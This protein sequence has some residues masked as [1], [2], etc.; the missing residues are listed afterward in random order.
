MF[1]PPMRLVIAYG[2]I[3][4]MALA[5]VGIVVW[6]RHNNPRRRYLR[7]KARDAEYYRRRDQAA[8]A[9]AEDVEARS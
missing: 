7:E 6:C 1:D 8:I 4:L 2:L 3:A 9:A 5:M